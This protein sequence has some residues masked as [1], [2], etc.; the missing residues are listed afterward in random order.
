LV[1]IGGAFVFA[2]LPLHLIEE[3][4]WR[5][6]Q[7][8]ALYVVIGL[9]RNALAAVAYALLLG[10]VFTDR[11]RKNRL[12]TPTA[13]TANPEAQNARAASPF[14]PGIKNVTTNVKC[15]D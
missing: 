10:A 2:W 8:T 5:F 6:E 14:E 15:R 7:T 9:I 3:R 12:Q 4:G 1:A 11:A 13:E